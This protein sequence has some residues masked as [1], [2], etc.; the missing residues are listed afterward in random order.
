MDHCIDLEVIE[1]KK[2]D[3]QYVKTEL[4]RF[5]AENNFLDEVQQ[6]QIQEL[7]SHI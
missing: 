4:K 2:V 5:V 3:L 1:E 6:L 7:L